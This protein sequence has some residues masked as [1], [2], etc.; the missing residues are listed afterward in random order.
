MKKC[1]FL[2][3]GLLL[4]TVSLSACGGQAD[5]SEEPV[6]RDV[7]SI[8][9]PAEEIFAEYGLDEGVHFSV[10]E[11][12]P[13]FVETEEEVSF[14]AG[15]VYFEIK[16]VEKAEMSS[17]EALRE[18]ISRWSEDYELTESRKELV[19]GHESLVTDIRQKYTDQVTFCYHAAVVDAGNRFY[20]ICYQTREENFEKYDAVFTRIMDSVRIEDE[21]PADN[22]GDVPEFDGE[23]VFEVPG[24]PYFTESEITDKTFLSFSAFDELGRCGTATACLGQEIAPVEER[25]PIGA[26]K[27]SG[28]HTVK[29]DGIEGNFLYN[30]CHL[31]GYQLCGEN[32]NELNLITGT[33]YMNVQGMEP[34]ERMTADYIKNSGHH[35][36]YRATPVFEGDDLVA[37][38]VLLEAQSVETDDFSFCVFCYNVQ[39]G[40]VIDYATG[41]SEGKEFT[42]NE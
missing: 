1:D 27:P 9:A 11:A 15:D 34:Y 20:V 16:S 13:V 25:G 29:Y 19:D 40:V 14:D 5:V 2:K 32:A 26:V 7:G 4:F 41:E 42:G 8:A 37:K 33:R 3:M 10:P 39:P 31:I 6:V 30:R 23:P 28:W 21:K 35:V 24:G 36:M 18:V 12:W 17:E 22:S 38:G